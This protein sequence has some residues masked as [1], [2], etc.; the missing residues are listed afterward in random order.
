MQPSVC[1]TS[2]NKLLRFLLWYFFAISL[3]GS[4]FLVSVT[5]TYLAV[6]CATDAEVLMLEEQ[7]S[8][9]FTA[10]L[11]ALLYW[12]GLGLTV[13]ILKRRHEIRS[14]SHEGY[15]SVEQELEELS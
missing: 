14:L 8:H 5:Q 7:S 10:C 2:D 1:F 6:L 15:V 4:I 3:A 13:Y 12:A 9:T 11:G